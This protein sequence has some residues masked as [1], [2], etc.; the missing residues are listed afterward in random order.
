MRSRGFTLMEL[1][2]VLV[3]TSFVTM[4]LLQALSQAYGLQ[5]RFAIQLVRGETG[6]MQL[7]W[8]RQV[9]QGVQPDLADAPGRFRGN[10]GGFSALA[11]DPLGAA[12]GASR[13]VQLAVVPDAG[14]GT[15]Q[16]AMRLG[17]RELVLASWPGLR[18]ATFV[19]LD[20]EG[21][22]HDQWPPPFGTWP[23]LPGVVALRLQGDGR[24][25]Q[26]V[27]VPRI[28]PKPAGTAAEAFQIFPP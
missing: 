28:S 23:A 4:M 2:V 3:I 11:T 7:D 9:V 26:I 13:L 10:A 21:R 17:Q 8:F 19:Y 1:L 12:E 16:L 25:E 20:A 15:V 18:E 22:A 14:A 27:A 5:R 6:A 24:D